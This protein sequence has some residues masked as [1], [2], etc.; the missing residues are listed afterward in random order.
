MFVATTAA[1]FTVQEEAVKTEADTDE[2]E[3]EDED[4]KQAAD[5]DKT[6][7]AEAETVGGCHT[8]IIH[9]V[10]VTHPLYLLCFTHCSTPQAYQNSFVT[11]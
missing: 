1:A 4:I 8:S 7:E 5:E 2:D 9:L 10:G 11:S 3:D 6:E